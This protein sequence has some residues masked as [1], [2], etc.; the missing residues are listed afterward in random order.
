MVFIFRF[1][2]QFPEVWYRG[3]KKYSPEDVPV[4]RRPYFTVDK[5]HPSMKVTEFPID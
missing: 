4:T 5:P 1:H 2:V 3:E